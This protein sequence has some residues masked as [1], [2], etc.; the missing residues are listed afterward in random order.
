MAVRGFF[1]DLDGTLGD[2]VLVL[3]KAYGEFMRRVGRP[4][5]DDE[6]DRLNGPPIASIV[7]HLRITHRLGGGQAELEQVYR[8]LVDQAYA[9]VGF[10][11]HAVE[12]LAAAKRGGLIVGVVTSNNARR[13]RAWLERTGLLPQ[14]DLVIS[15]DDVSRGKPDP[16]SYRRALLQAGAEPS[17]SIAVEDSLQGAAAARAAG[18]P[19]F[20]LLDRRSRAPRERGVRAIRSL[21]ELLP[22]LDAPPIRATISRLAS[23]RPGDRGRRPA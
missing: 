21:A 17:L 6:F 11:P 5:S 10:M 3:R 1:A 12:V 9:R 19:T 22:L 23:R 13:A 20:L 18:L 2:S 7:S 15:G 8:G 4:P 14:V 16:E